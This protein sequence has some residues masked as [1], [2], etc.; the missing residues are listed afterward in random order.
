[1]PT[2][3]RSGMITEAE[4]STLGN[5]RRVIDLPLEQGAL[6]EELF[7]LVLFRR[8]YENIFAH[9]FEDNVS[10]EEYC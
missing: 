6:K 8:K 1:M 3:D 7:T 4:F 2:Y 5:D 10:V 9:I